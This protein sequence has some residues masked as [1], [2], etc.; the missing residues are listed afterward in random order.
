M[1]ALIYLAIT[2]ILTRVFKLVEYLISGERRVAVE[3]PLIEAGLHNPGAL[4]K[5]EL[6]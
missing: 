3:D 5:A 4:Q 6:R 1:A 2:F